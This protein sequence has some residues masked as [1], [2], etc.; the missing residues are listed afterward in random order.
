MVKITRIGEKFPKY[1]VTVLNPKN[2]E[3]IDE[4]HIDEAVAYRMYLTRS[5]DE[6]KEYYETGVL[7]PH[8]KK[9]QAI[10]KKEYFND[11]P[12]FEVKESAPTTPTTVD[13]S[14]IID[15]EDLPF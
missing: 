6:L 4:K 1:E 9:E 10:S 3:S 5:V 12:K 8:K 13:T 15:D 7:P 14:D 11:K 2:F